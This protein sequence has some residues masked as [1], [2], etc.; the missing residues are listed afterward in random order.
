[1]QGDIAN[2]QG[3]APALVGVEALFHTAAYFRES[4]QG[5]AHWEQLHRINVLG[6]TELFEAAYAAGVRRAIHTSSIATLDGEPGQWIDETMWRK[7]ED[8]D[9]YYR[10][11]IQAD[12][13]VLKFLDR[14]P[15]FWAAF[16]LPG[17]MHGPG[18]SAPTSAGQTVLDFM[19]RKLP[20]IV[21]GSFSVVDARDVALAQVL[22]LEKG[23]RGTRY[24][25]AGREISLA[26]LV[27][28]LEGLTGIPA[29]RRRLPVWL[30]YIVGTLEELKARLT[31]KPAL[32]S[33]AT[34]RLLE[35]EEGR[36]RYSHALTERELGLRFRPLEE[37]L[38]DEVSWFRQHGYVL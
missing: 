36:S 21:P 25:A 19:H 14:H 29:P 1:V 6:T 24:L 33:L 35:R 12:R 31:G 23:V 7:E 15:D 28:R 11:K 34:V 13:A 9:D 37:T 20:G 26:D 17:W 8:A 4:Y 2:V 38:R 5:G 3:F 16:V 10:S 18:D 32:L 30:L 27:N 22:A